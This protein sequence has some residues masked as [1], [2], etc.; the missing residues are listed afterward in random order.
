MSQVYGCDFPSD[1]DAMTLTDWA[2]AVMIVEEL[3]EFSD[4]DLRGRIVEQAEDEVEGDEMKGR[5][6][7]EDILREVSRR[8]K[9]APH[10][11]PFRHTEFG[12]ERIESSSISIYSFLLFLS[13][14]EV[15][16]R[17]AVYSNE[18]TPL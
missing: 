17:D 1:R 12:I 10:T 18:I 4:A 11:Y 6:Q 3:P 14:R 7:V 13:M 5:Q 15:P 9:Y 8:S 2:E 16:F